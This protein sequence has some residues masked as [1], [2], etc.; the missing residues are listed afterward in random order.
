MNLP[1]CIG[2]S[3]QDGNRVV[4][5]TLYKDKLEEFVKKEC[6]C[7]P[8][9]Y[10]NAISDSIYKTEGKSLD[11]C[12][13]ATITFYM[14]GTETKYYCKDLSEETLIWEPGINGHA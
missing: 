12:S 2:I 14:N 10:R 11:E 5:H 9:K 6:A 3:V 4:Y 7:L 1:E 13:S 8:E